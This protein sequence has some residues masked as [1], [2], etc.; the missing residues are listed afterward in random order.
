MKEGQDRFEVWGLPLYFISFALYYFPAFRRY[1]LR[2]NRNPETF[3]PLLWF[4]WKK[5]L[6]LGKRCRPA[7]KAELPFDGK[8]EHSYS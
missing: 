2:G 1:L 5:L 7:E 3:N 6:R 8:R 4:K